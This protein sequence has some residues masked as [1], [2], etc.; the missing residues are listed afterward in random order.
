MEVQRWLMEL[1]HDDCVRLL[2][3][4]ELGRLAVIVEGRPEIFPVNHVYEP[5]RTSIAFATMAGTKL[6][7]A[8][9]WPWVAYEV[10]GV[11]DDN[12]AGWS[13]LVVGHV[14]EI[15]DA[16]EIDRLDAQRGLALWASGE[17]ARWL[18]I[19]P[20]KITGRRVSLGH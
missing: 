19:I 20:N 16:A 5:E 2:A 14:E 1:P 9:D 7:G 18:R 17:G 15:T 13:V 6:H 8:L 4:C 12:R 3:D 11:D 10:D